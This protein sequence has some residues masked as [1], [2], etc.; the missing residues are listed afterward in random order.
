MP[1]YGECAPPRVRALHHPFR[2]D[3][4]GPLPLLEMGLN[5]RRTGSSWWVDRVVSSEMKP[6]K[7]GCALRPRRSDSSV[8]TTL[9]RFERRSGADELTTAQHRSL[10]IPVLSPAERARTGSP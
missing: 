8:C 9:I 10:D 6:R 3:S 1:Y 4:E 2:L 5:D 7:N